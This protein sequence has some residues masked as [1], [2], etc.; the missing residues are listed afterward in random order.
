MSVHI[1]SRYGALIPA[2]CMFLFV[3]APASAVIIVP[4]G[5]GPDDGTELFLPSDGSI[6]VQFENLGDPSTFGFYF[7]G[8]DLSDPASLVPIFG[9]EDM[10]P[11]QTAG[12][13][14]DLGIVVDL[15]AGVL[16]S[17]FSGHGPIGFFWL[18]PVATL[19]TEAALQGGID[20]AGTFPSLV[21][22]SEYVVA[23]EIPGGPT[24]A[25][26][27]ISGIRPLPEP[28][29]LLLLGVGLLALTSR[30]RR[31]PPNSRSR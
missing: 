17:T 22:D 7:A 21:A 16:Q 1:K 13:D 24:V 25:Y 28:T 10:G 5:F 30:A 4:P 12:I 26:E 20:V 18:S 14:F 11:G 2:L 31:S 15:D 8:T 23:F 29:S 9:P 27:F 6:V 19:F 3:A